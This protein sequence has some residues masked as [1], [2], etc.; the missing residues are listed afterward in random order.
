MHNLEQ[1]SRRKYLNLETFRR[2][3]VGV[4]TPVWFV[5]LGET[6]YVIT[7]SNS[8]K[9]KRIKNDQQV[10]IVPSKVDGKPVGSWVP[11]ICNLV[12]DEALL[13][14]VDQMYDMKYGVLKKIFFRSKK[15]KPEDYSILELKLI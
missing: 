14:R 11:A 6:L 5:Q 2:S 15:D 9:V 4:K 13:G 1:F 3:G 7:F 8:G 10:R 12:N